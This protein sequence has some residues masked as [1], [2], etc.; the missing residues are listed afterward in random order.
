METMDMVQTADIDEVIFISVEQ[1]IL[2]KNKI[3]QTF[4]PS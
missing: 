4:V 1:I 2:S 3:K